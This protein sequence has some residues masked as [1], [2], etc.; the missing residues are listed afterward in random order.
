M[1]CDFITGPDSEH[2]PALPAG[3]WLAARASGA[4]PRGSDISHR[5][6]YT[7]L[8]NIAWGATFLGGSAIRCSPRRRDAAYVLHRIPGSSPCCRYQGI[9]G[10]VSNASE[11]V[12]RPAH[13]VDGTRLTAL[14]YAAWR[15]SEMRHELHVAGTD[16]LADHQVCDVRH[17]RPVGRC[18]RWNMSRGY[19]IGRPG[20]R[21]PAR[22]SAGPVPIIG[23][24]AC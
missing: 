23:A 16:P 3:L 2:P 12:A 5:S 18:G 7:T 20:P 4:A 10:C 11:L 1:R 24:S 19:L 17:D 9:S 14:W 21:L 13:Q 15:S 8:T 6:M 22:N